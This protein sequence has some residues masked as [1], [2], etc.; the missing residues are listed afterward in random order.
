MMEQIDPQAEFEG[1]NS[2]LAEGRAEDAV[3][4]YRR[5]L[6]AAPDVVEIHHNLTA[7]LAQLQRLQEAAEV[8]RLGLSRRPNYAPLHVVL[9]NLLS[10]AEGQGDQEAAKE[11]FHQALRLNNNLA[12]AWSGLAG[13]LMAEGSYENASEKYYNALKLN[14]NDPVS[15][16]NLAICQLNLGRQHDAL[17][18]YRDLVLLSPELGSAH[19]NLGQVLQGLGRHDEAVDAFRRALELDQSIDNLAPFLMQ[20][21]MYQCAWDDLDTIKQRVLTETRRRLADG[22]P[23]TVQPFSLAGTDAPADLRLAAARSYSAYCAANVAALRERLGFR[24]APRTTARLRVGYISPD[25]RQHSVATAFKDLIAQHDR[26]NFEWFAYAIGREQRDDTTDYFR[27]QF[28]HFNDFKDV[29]LENA[30]RRIHGDQLDLLI[31]LSGFTRHSALEILET[32][33]APVQAHY[34]GYGATLG[35]DCVQYLITDAVHTPPELARHCAE[36]VVYLPDSFMATS[37]PEIAD[38]V[39]DRKSQGLPEDGV[40]F[41][42]FNA[43]YKFDPETFALWLDLLGALPGSVLWLLRGG[44]GAMANLC[45][46]ARAK[47]IDA[48][49]LIFAPR[50]PHPEHLARQSLAD[51]S[52]DCRHHAGGVSTL[53]AL[54]S[55]LPVLSIAGDN[56]SARTGA[57]ILHAA[58]LPELVVETMTDYRATA[59]RLARDPDALGAL[60]ARLRA[61]LDTAPL[62]DTARLARHLEAAYGEMVRRNRAGEGIGSFSAAQVV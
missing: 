44:D 55:G 52:L 56:Q 20:S 14:K 39:P 42:N 29:D 58:G 37:R 28:D 16:N 26:R 6:E 57:S 51:L 32:R 49:R 34:L 53:D 25:F 61:N 23:I 5:A 22:L 7:A 10:Q 15:I 46:T 8:A 11:H 19:N 27:E 18:L 2:A 41:A 3:V 45:A 60:K 9:G 62:F 1:G 24:H 30:A 21:L 59:L 31:D 33:P 13:I 35:A 47:G 40:V 48:E 38:A 50:A 43:H 17:A 54:W 12:S 36:A 4:H